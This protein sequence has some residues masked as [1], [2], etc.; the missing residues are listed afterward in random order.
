MRA[1]DLAYPVTASPTRCALA[2]VAKHAPPCINP[3]ASSVVPV[4]A[5]V[6]HHITAMLAAHM[7]AVMAVQA[8]CYHAIVPESRAAMEAKRVAGLGL[9]CVAVAA[10]SGELDAYLIAMPIRWP[11]LPALDSEPAPERDADTLYVHDMALHPRA[12]GTGLAARLMRGVLQAAQQQ[13]LR[14]AALIAIQGSQG[15][16]QAQ[17]FAPVRPDTGS[18]G[19]K[20]RSYGEDALLMRCALPALTLAGAVGEGPQ[21]PD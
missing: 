3:F 21:A 15:F 16:W 12:R 5:P 19:D 8:V 11:Q 13:G 20:L 17:G 10:S 2:R 4:S 6:H 18:L 9:P 1:A 7:D 14:Q